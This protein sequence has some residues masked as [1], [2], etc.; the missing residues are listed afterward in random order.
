M[1]L[2]QVSYK[3]TLDQDQMVLRKTSLKYLSTSADF[4]LSQLERDYQTKKL[5]SAVLDSL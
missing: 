4:F 2:L 3:T 1:L 5:I